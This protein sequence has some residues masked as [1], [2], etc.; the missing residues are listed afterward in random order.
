MLGHFRD[1]DAAERLHG[2]A[3]TLSS[4]AR[5]CGWSVPACFISEDRYEEAGGVR[6]PLCGPWYRPAVQETAHLLQLLDRDEEAVCLLSDA[7]ER[8]RAARW[9]PRLGVL[10]AE[11]GRHADAWQSWDR[12][13]QLSPL[14]DG[15]TPLA[16]G[17]AVGHG[18]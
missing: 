6:G 4:A 5:G 13:D 14:L 18:L 7:A 17:S 9:W 11:I 12:F 10:Q 2:R 8:I 16:G 1:F 15:R 3:E